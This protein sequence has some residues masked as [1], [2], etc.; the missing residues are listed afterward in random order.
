MRVARDPHLRRQILVFS[1]LALLVGGQLYAVIT[2]EEHWPF[3]PYPMYAELNQTREYKVIR[4]VGVTA[5]PG[6]RELTLD[7]AWLR[8]SLA[9][10]ARHPQ[11]DTM[12]LKSARSYVQK[13]SWRNPHNRDAP[14]LRALRIYE[15]VWDLRG[16]ASNQEAPDR[17][18]RLLEFRNEEG[19]PTILPTSAPQALPT[20]G[21]GSESALKTR[22]GGG[23]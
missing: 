14:H 7:S 11:A 5:P 10:A 22:D 19:Q 17:V 1:L 21:T 12:L 2:S 4:L 15:Q 6:S 23:R 3:S 8:K 20:A 9:K 18:R 16:D 13:Y